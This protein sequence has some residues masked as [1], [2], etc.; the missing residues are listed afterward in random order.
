[1]YQTHSVGHTCRFL[2]FYC[3]NPK[4][5]FVTGILYI[6][7]Y[8]WTFYFSFT[9]LPV[10]ITLPF[11]LHTHYILLCNKK[12]TVQK[13][14]KVTYLL[15]LPTP[16]PF[17]GLRLSPQYTENSQLPANCI[18][19]QFLHHLKYSLVV[20][21]MMNM[22]VLDIIHCLCIAPLNVGKTFGIDFM[23]YV[24]NID[25]MFK[26]CYDIISIT[27]TTLKVSIV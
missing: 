1:M 22:Q 14:C 15:T 19:Q 6:L 16:S 21:I 8:I 18:Y 11:Q 2:S 9:N 3:I 5:A 23:F 25:L 7:F 17:T 24:T 12:T 27:E 26:E 20:T 13:A 4:A 10:L